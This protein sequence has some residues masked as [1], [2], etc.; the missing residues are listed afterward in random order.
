MTRTVEATVVSDA[1]VPRGRVSS[2][3]NEMCSG[4]AKLEHESGRFRL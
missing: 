4:G 1:D 2:L 3:R